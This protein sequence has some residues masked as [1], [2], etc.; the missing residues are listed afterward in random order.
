MFA[1]PPKDLTAYPFVHYP[2]AV[3]HIYLCIQIFHLYLCVNINK[4]KK[5]TS[6]LQEMYFIHQ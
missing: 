6:N 2:F 3:E 5:I 4:N 1:K